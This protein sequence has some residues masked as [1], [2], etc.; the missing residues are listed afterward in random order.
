MMCEHFLTRQSDKPDKPGNPLIQRGNSL[1]AT[2]Q[3]VPTTPDRT[4]GDAQ[5][6]VGCTRQ[7]SSRLSGRVSVSLQG[8]D[9]P[10]RVVGCRV[11]TCSST[12]SRINSFQGSPPSMPSF[13]R[14]PHP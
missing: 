11:L 13:P 1:K 7:S 10:C 8:V 14:N 2:R 3:T 12:T 9:L 6:F 4:S 5:A